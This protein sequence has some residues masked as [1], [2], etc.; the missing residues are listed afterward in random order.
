MI[1]VPG[2]REACQRVEARRDRAWTDA[3]VVWQVCGLPLRPMTVRDYAR[4]CATSSWLIGRSEPT[5]AGSCAAVWLLSPH[6][7]PSSRWHRLRTW[8]RAWRTDPEDLVRGLDAY[9]AEQLADA[10]AHRAPGALRR[11]PIASMVA[12]LVASLAVDYRMDV[13]KALN[14]PIA[15]ALQLVR[16]S[17][18]RQGLRVEWT[19]EAERVKLN[20]L[21]DHNERQRVAREVAATVGVN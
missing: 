7:S 17:A 15:Q 13:D 21:R 5:H 9:V 6:Y 2:Y 20:W 14:V 4:L 11:A 10:Q 19:D 12:D 18:V 1:S 16:M 3:P 8:W